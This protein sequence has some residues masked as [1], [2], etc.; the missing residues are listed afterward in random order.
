MLC[1]FGKI[2]LRCIRPKL[3]LWSQPQPQL[4]R[5]AHLWTT[6]ELSIFRTGPLLHRSTPLRVKVPQSHSTHSQPNECA[7]SLWTQCQ[8]IMKSYTPCP[9]TSHFYPPFQVSQTNLISNL[10]GRNF[11]KLKPNH[12]THCLKFFHGFQ[13]SSE[14]VLWTLWHRWKLFVIKSFHT[15]SYSASHTVPACFSPASQ[16]LHIIFFAQNT[17]IP[18]IFT[19]LTSSCLLGLNL[20]DKTPRTTSLTPQY[21]LVTLSYAPVVLKLLS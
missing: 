8:S 12:R 6:S 13:L 16:F 20:D 9:Q 5:V 3:P 15:S 17:F 11:P 2:T 7:S 18:S 4:Q 1:P 14:W 10:S 19:W 21:D